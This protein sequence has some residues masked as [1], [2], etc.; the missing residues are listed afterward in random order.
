MGWPAETVQVETRHNASLGKGRKRHRRYQ[1]TRLEILR[2]A[3]R[4]FSRNGFALATM[5]EIGD[6]MQMTKAS[7]YYYFRSK[8]E[9]LYFCQDYSLDAMLKGAR[10]ILRA[11]TAADAQLS[12]IIQNQLRCM[13]DELQASAA[14][15]EFRDLPAPMLK[16]IIR[17]RDRYE[18]L[19]RSVVERGIQQRVF[20]PCDSRVV[21]W[22]ILGALN[23]TAQ[24]Y[25][26]GGLLS[27]GQLA[28]QF[29][30][31]L[32]CGLRAHA[33]KV[34]KTSDPDMLAAGR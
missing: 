19:L 28:A 32:L 22:A 11:E 5:Q 18:R 27:A 16:K 12:A 31:F 14:H 21:V 20:R 26:P 9:L 2:S 25:A 13:L 23:W 7:L 1:G 15:I 4:E 29:A 17:K 24:W 33:G 30:D 10:E 3:A 34:S 6:R 8:Q